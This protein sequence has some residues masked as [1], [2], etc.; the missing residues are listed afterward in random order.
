MSIL[1]AIILGLVQGLTEFLP[2]SSSGHLSVAQHLFYEPD[3][4]DDLLDVMLHLG[5][6]LAVFIVFYKKILKYI[7]EFVG[8]VKDV[9]TRKFKWA[10]MSDSRRSVIM[11]FV[12][13]APLVLIVPFHDQIKMINNTDNLLSEGFSFLFTGAML[14]IASKAARLNSKKRTITFPTA[15][16]IG[17]MQAIAASLAGVSRSGS[18]IAIA[19]IL[20]LSKEMAVEFSF[21][22]S[23]PTILAAF[24]LELHKADTSAM[25][26]TSAIIGIIVAAAVGVFAISALRWLIKKDKF[27]WFGFY[28]L[29]LGVVCLGISAFGW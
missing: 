24:A 1:K 23:I 10:E 20:G 5:T 2:I 17:V 11:L 3:I 29:G 16:A 27:H 28:C 22:M 18:T 4:L 19:L 7:L 14:L 6:L 9:F 8:L 13:L 12:A 26:W 25:P 15:L 21:I